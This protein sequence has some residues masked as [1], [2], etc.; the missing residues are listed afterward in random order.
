MRI[1]FL[2]KNLTFLGGV[3]R[4]ITTLSNFW[5]IQNEVYIYSLYGDEKYAYEISKN[6]NIILG[7]NDNK[8]KIKKYLKIYKDVERIV[9]TKNI[10]MI[11][12]ENIE[13]NSLAALL[14]KKYGLI[15]IGYEHL[16]YKRMGMREEILRRIF[17]SR[18]TYFVLPNK[19]EEKNYDKYKCNSIFIPN[20]LS[21]KMKEKANTDT[22]IILN[23]GRLDYVKGHD[24]LLE[25]FIK[26]LKKYP[27]KKLIIVGSDWG[28]KENLLLKIKE[29]NLKE[30][31]YLYEGNNN[32]EKYLKTA[33]MFIL[34][35]RE[36]G[37]S[38]A[39]LEAMESGVP[40]IASNTIGPSYLIKDKKNGL[41]FEKENIASLTEKILLLIEDR[42]LKNNI[43][44]EGLKT[45]ELYS[46]ENITKIWNTKLEEFNQK[47]LF[48][49]GEL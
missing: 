25:A 5:S 28:E 17:Y 48:K 33:S 23:I 47:I 42:N 49:K 19:I 37:F 20:P 10:E 4:F 29:E 39:M 46:V 14:G 8:S 1:L 7:K 44:E 15:T 35:S 13:T 16:S 32:I 11:I 45:A 31:V 6:V 9:K 36:E 38:M 40:L 30:K 27:N 43:I 12:G 26:V 2:A 18:L 22:D 34:P 41:L 21:F 24:I 3:E